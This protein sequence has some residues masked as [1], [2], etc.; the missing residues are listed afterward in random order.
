MPTQKPKSPTHHPLRNTFALLFVSVMIAGL[1]SRTAIADP[2]SFNY[3][4]RL[5]K[6]SGEPLGSPVK[7]QVKFFREK[8]GGSALL[9]DG[10]NALNFDEVKL[11]DGLFHLNLAIPAADRNR[12]FSNNEDLWI[13]VSHVIS[14]DKVVTYSRQRFAATPYALKVPVD[15]ESIIYNSAGQLK[16]N[17]QVDGQTILYDDEGR[18]KVAPNNSSSVSIS[19]GESVSEAPTVTFHKDLNF[20]TA[21]PTN[22]SVLVASGTEGHMSWGSVSDLISSGGALT[23]FASEGIDDNS[24]GGPASLT[25][26]SNKNINIG[27][28]NSKT[29]LSVGGGISRDYIRGK[30][31][32]NGASTRWFRLG[33]LTSDA[34]N[35]YV[36]KLE[37]I[38]LNDSAVGKVTIVTAQRGNWI[39]GYWY[40]E[41][42]RANAPSS[43]PYSR[44]LNV[45]SQVISSTEF[46]LYAQIPANLTFGWTAELVGPPDDTAIWTWDLPETGSSSGPSE[47]T[48]NTLEPRD[49]WLVIGA[50]EIPGFAPTFQNGWKAYRPNNGEHYPAIRK[51]RDGTIQFRGVIDSTDVT[52]NCAD[53]VAI[54]LPYST[55]GYLGWY[56][57]KLPGM[58]VD[59]N[60]FAVYSVS[61]GEISI[62]SCVSGGKYSFDGVFYNR[63]NTNGGV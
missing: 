52:G 22:N 13:E 35:K 28:S 34:S 25:I 7:L 44:V 42:T 2:F 32:S 61:S 24:G 10:E 15:N 3:S 60:S 37:G 23:N 58:R 39:T 41:G 45:K 6:S 20:P 33:T 5:V 47:G 26:D 38:L 11:K 62:P 1:P 8:S 27:T 31:H 12:L 21:T 40:W 53:K 9:V 57:A 4:G 30:H 43:F 51:T 16:A 36:I 56:P 49:V 48:V 14:E 54:R 55:W 17:V 19:K 29:K 50:S 46:H 63:R 18:L 59:D